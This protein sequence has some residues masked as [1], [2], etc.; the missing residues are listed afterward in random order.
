MAFDL[1]TETD[2]SF[3]ADSDWECYADDDVEFA[4][5]DDDMQFESSDGV[6][7]PFAEDDE[8]VWFAEASDANG[9]L[10]AAASRP[11]TED[12]SAAPLGSDSRGSVAGTLISVVLHV[13]LLLN[14]AQLVIDDEPG[15]YEPPLEAFIVNDKPIEEEELKTVEYVLA[16]PDERELEV[17]EVINAARIGM[18]ATEN[19]R[20]ESAP[21]QLTELLPSPREQ[22]VYDVPEGLE[23]DDRIVVNGTTGRELVQIDSALDLITWEIANNLQESRV[24]IVWLLDASGSLTEQRKA[25]ARRLRRIYG[26]L[27]A[28]Q[29]QTDQ[30]PRTEL[31]LLSG[32][33]TFGEKTT[34]VTPQPTENFDEIQSAIQNVEVDQSGVENIFGAVKQVCS[35]WSRYRTTQRRRILL[36][37]VTD[38]AGD[39][40]SQS[41]EP[42]INVCQRFG[43]KAYV[44]GPTA[45]FGRRQGFVPYRAPEDGKMYQ[46]PVDLGPESPVMETVVLPFWYAGSQFENLSSGFAPYALA[47][48]V[49][50]TGGVYF[51]TNMTTMSGLTP[52]GVFD[53]AT[54]RTFAPDYRFGTAEDYMRD[55]A[56]HPLRK[57]VVE[58]SIMSRTTQPPGTPQLYFAV[59]SGNFRQTATEAQ[60]SAAKGQYMVESILQSFPPGIEKELAREDSARWRV[61]F[62]LTY[63]RLLAQRV[64]NLEY[65]YGLAW[66]K[67]NLA[68]DDVDTKANR[69]NIRPSQKLNYAGTMRKTA[70]L[71]EELLQRV[72]DE[73]PGT[74]WAVLASRE[75][76]DGFGIEIQQSYVAPPPPRPP[77]PRNTAPPK[78]KVQF[79]PDPKK[80]ATPPPPPPKP[81]LP[82]L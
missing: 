71:A 54:L 44:V 35:N 55:L 59:T 17:R 7:V 25:I 34:F 31:P 13:A 79:A 33:V 11:T 46:L 42:A 26:E 22:H 62:C 72:V 60:K 48:L 70:T 38:E 51:T 5:V 23:V 68:N 76:K 61:N 65:N 32:V 67:S 69:W 8:A 66:V 39:D 4:A 77:A 6:D 30:L 10:A 73:A 14:L 20:R 64:R 1:P 36:I 29:T 12:T 49:H 19:P 56:K 58:A 47:R 41:L 16:N 15:W 50:E 78:N 82:K 18:A 37:T 75:L 63:G 53:A 9:E 40:F 80:P 52:T 21:Q 43:A 27:N 3:D 81:V 45:V 2:S 24:L 57:A 28:L 74:P